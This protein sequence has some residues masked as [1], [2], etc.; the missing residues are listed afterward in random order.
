VPAFAAQT[1]A[2][3][4]QN[5]ILTA[6][7]LIGSTAVMG[8]AGAIS[9]R[10]NLASRAAIQP[11]EELLGFG[12]NRALRALPGDR[13]TAAARRL[14][15]DN[16][17]LIFSE[18]A[19]IATGQRIGG[20]I[21]GLPDRDF[22]LSPRQTDAVDA[23][24]DAQ[25]APDA[26]V[27]RPQVST[28]VLEPETAG[29]EIETETET[30]TET[31]AGT[32]TTTEEFDVP[33][34]ALVAEGATDVDPRLLDIEGGPT[35]P[36][37]EVETETDRSPT[38]GEAGEIEAGGAPFAGSE[39]L[40]SGG[41]NEFGA[42][43]DVP[44]TEV[45][46]ETTATTGETGGDPPL[47]D[48]I[49][50]TETLPGGAPAGEAPSGPTIPQTE[51][52]DVL[53][54]V[55]DNVRD[56]VSDERGRAS[57]ADPLT[58]SETGPTTSVDAETETGAD[59][60]RS[61]EERRQEVLDAR[62]ELQAD[63][64]RRT[65]T[66]P[67]PTPRRGFDAEV[68]RDIESGRGRPR[69]RTDPAFDD[70]GGE[71]LGV[72]G[73]DT[74]P[75]AGPAGVPGRPAGVGVGEF[76]DAE[77]PTGRQ[78]PRQDPAPEPVE[79]FEDG[80]LLPEL[81]PAPEP[82]L[83]QARDLQSDLDRPADPFEEVEERR[84][85]AQT[86]FAEADADA[87]VRQRTRTEALTDVRADARAL[88]DVEQRPAVREDIRQDLRQD[89]RQETETFR[90]V[91]QE[92]ESEVEAETEVEAR[93]EAEREIEQEL[94]SELEQELRR[95]VETEGLP[96]DDEPPEEPLFGGFEL[97]G[98]RDVDVSL[99]RTEVAFDDVGREFP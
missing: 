5:P 18:E 31:G 70:V 63:I 53:D 72:A 45:E 27:D 36:T 86:P 89:I 20:A 73:P 22:S 35:T 95:E 78:R 59:V 85:E 16:E 71:A 56:L 2:A 90:E 96:S 91:E 9:N 68:R 88:L 43:V 81:D 25:L 62:R 94:E 87:D 12:G 98:A 97:E 82:E 34:S 50:E 77:A 8:G 32:R 76:E 28:S 74:D 64:D 7:T 75:A 3:A 84:R 17:P 39:P 42:P 49:Q 65:A 37:L 1:V 4:R 21:R 58:R 79:D 93:T 47:L 14:F 13:T 44:G 30:E 38:G 40:G 19:A 10:A 54:Q 55:P 69:P 92:L 80:P 57:L 51:V 67:E 15:P 26:S 83:E 66:E 41:A 61:L 46:T 60:S 99:D 24:R 29:T 11:G 48:E 33:T 23:V 52:D 6:G